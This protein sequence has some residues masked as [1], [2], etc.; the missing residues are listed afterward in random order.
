[1]YN[2]IKPICNNHIDEETK[3][4]INNLVNGIRDR[5]RALSQEV[6][7]WVSSTDGVFLSSDVYRG[8]QLSTRQEQKNLSIILKRLCKE[9]LIER[10]GK[11]HGEW[12]KINQD[13][14]PMDYMNAPDEE[15]NLQLPLNIHKL[16]KIY[17]GNIIVVAG[18]SNV[19][20]TCFMLETVRLNQRTHKVRYMN[21]EMGETELKSR[22]SN[23]EEVIKLN[24]W[25][26]EAIERANNW[27]DIIRPDDI[28]IIDFMEIYDNF[29]KIGE[30][31]NNIHMKLKKG[32]CIIAVQKQSSTKGKQVDF[33]RGG[34]FTL[35][36]PRLYLSMD[37]GKIKVV[38]AKS[39]RGKNPNGLVR[40]FKLVNGWVFIPKGDWSNGQELSEE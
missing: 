38:K 8:L 4:K 11:R 3:A 6:R 2:L 32:I 1:V 27:W 9:E 22:L 10:A 33:G 31:L 12:R 16:V 19:G 36:K 25:S 23:F 13:Y 20:K 34:E 37:R 29:Y 40:E 15:F 26:F 28:N 35:E 17:P 21:S 39:F 14:E 7:E 24:D 30:W 5:E 18:A